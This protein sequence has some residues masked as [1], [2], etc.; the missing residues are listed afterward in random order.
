MDFEFTE[1]QKLFRESLREFLDKEIAPIVDERDRKGSLTK[2]ETIGFMKKFKKIGIGFDPES[3]KEMAQDFMLFAIF[4][5][6]TFRVW[7]SLAATLGINAGTMAVVVAPDAMR[8]KLLPKL[9]AAELCGC[10]GITEPGHGSN[11]SILDTKAVL[12]G[13]EYVINGQKTWISNAPIADICMLVAMDAETDM[14]S[15]FLVDK[16]ES[17][18]EVTELHKIGWKAFPTGELFFDD[19]RIPKENNLMNMIGE[20]L[21]G[22]ERRS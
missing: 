6:E 8:E 7:P 3:L 11:S 10:A 5:E 12:D 9:E 1:D 2:E 4:A 14:Q 19:C 15:F 22:G 16:E 17:P 21:S 13:D 20:M 18:F